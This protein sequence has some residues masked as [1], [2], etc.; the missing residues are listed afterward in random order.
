MS[1]NHSH[2]HCNDESHGHDHD[3]PEE[4]GPRDIL[5]SRI[6]R[7]NVVALNSE[8]G[9]GPEVIKPWD[10]RLDETEVSYRI[11]FMQSSST[12]LAQ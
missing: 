8:S 6:D 9:T 5:Y 2:G 3:I 1:H 4:Q 11:S 10:K 12:Y 7:P